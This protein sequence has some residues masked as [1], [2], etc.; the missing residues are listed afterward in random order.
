MRLSPTLTTALATA[1]ALALTACGGNSPDSDPETT[2]VADG[3]MTD[4]GLPDASSNATAMEPQ[5]FVEAMAAS[6]RFELESAR[7][8]QAKSP[9]AAV[10]DFAEMMIRDHTA[11]TDR[12]KAVLAN[13]A[14]V[15]APATPTLTAAQQTQLE[16][17]RT[18]SGASFATLYMRQQVTAHETALATLTSFANAG[19]HAGLRQFAAN[20]AQTVR[21]HLEHARSLQSPTSAAGDGRGAG[22]GNNNANGPGTGADMS[23]DTGTTG[24]TAT[25]PPAR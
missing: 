9:P 17:L 14:S 3:E 4:T 7:I 18:A 15:R 5:A 23:G 20:T 21:G 2:T 19:S 10:R 1:A 6:D 25:P 8:A 16:Q 11:S 22:S 24:R 12:L 13:D